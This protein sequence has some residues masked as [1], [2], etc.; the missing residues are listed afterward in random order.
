MIQ[1]N[2]K[3]LAGTIQIWL[4]SNKKTKT[5]KKRDNMYKGSNKKLAT[6]TI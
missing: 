6:F 3:Q 4:K 5:N 2:Q 1:I